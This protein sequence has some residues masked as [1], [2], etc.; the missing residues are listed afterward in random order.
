MATA[1]QQMP[2]HVECAYRDATDNVLFLQRQQWAA[3]IYALLIYAAIFLTSAHY[4]SR[5][6]FARNWLGILTIL[7]FVVHWYMLFLFQGQINVLKNRLIWIY[8]TYF[9]A[10]ERTGLGLQIEP[11]S[12]W[13]QPEA[14]VGLIAV[15][16][17]AALLT[18]IY[19]WSVR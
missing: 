13:Y 4:F 16:F 6:D 9:N 1:V 2:G 10:E 15:S 3:T 19:L 8:R 11:R 18:G 12:Y 14:F 7:T 5:T 17:I